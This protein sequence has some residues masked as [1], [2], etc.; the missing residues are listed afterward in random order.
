[1][2]LKMGPDWLY[3]MRIHGPVLVFS[4]FWTIDDLKDGA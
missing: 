4:G 1:M 2:T 3:D